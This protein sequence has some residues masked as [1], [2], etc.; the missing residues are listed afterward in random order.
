MEE[1]EGEGVA[2]SSIKGWSPELGG[3]DMSMAKGGVSSLSGKLSPAIFLHL[4]LEG[5][6][7]LSRGE[8]K[9]G[10]LVERLMALS[11]GGQRALSGS[12]S[13]LKVLLKSL[14]FFRLQ[15]CVSVDKAALANKER[16]VKSV[17]VDEI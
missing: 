15:S 17:G 8:K 14:G 7:M 10:F 3:V 11:D 5:S 6:G 2:G 16:P 13:S 12:F 9:L 4:K 1:G